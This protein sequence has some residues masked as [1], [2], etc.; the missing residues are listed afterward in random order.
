ME[1]KFGPCQKKDKETID[2]NRGEIFKKKQ[3]GTP[4]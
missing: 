4:F 3:A 1:A 2:I